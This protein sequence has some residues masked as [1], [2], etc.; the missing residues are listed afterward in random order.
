MKQ[1]Q[2]RHRLWIATTAQEAGSK[3]SAQ[4]LERLTRKRWPE[5]RI[6]R[7]D[8]ETIADPSHDAS[9][10]AADPDGIAGAYDVV[11]ATPAV[12]AG[13]SVTLRG[14]FAAVLVAA[15]GT[16][17]PEGVAQ[18]AAYGPTIRGLLEREGYQLLKADALNQKEAAEAAAIGAELQEISEDALAAEDEAVMAAEL[19]S[20][21]EALAIERKRRRLNPFWKRCEGA[22]HGRRRVLK[23]GHP[24]QSS[25]QP[26]ACSYSI[27]RP[28]APWELP[29]SPLSLYGI[30]WAVRPPAAPSSC[31][32]QAPSSCLMLTPLGRASAATRYRQARF[33]LTMLRWAS[34]R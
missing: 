16:T 18:A 33:P 29:R 34:R 12:A 24:G 10:L 11:V 9:R 28:P 32:I 17:D 7:V 15:G 5:A 1:L 8:S 21:R 31:S 27:Q 6:L 3:N 19:L 22:V 4:V 26:A 14:H 2:Q 23:V 25:H 30:F 13:L 20:D